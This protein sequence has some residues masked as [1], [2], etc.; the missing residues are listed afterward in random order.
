MQ[1]EEKAKLSYLLKHVE[2]REGKPLY[3]FVFCFAVCNNTKANLSS[4]F[5]ESREGLPFDVGCWIGCL[6]LVVAVVEVVV[7]GC[8]LLVAG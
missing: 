6:L 5:A 1:K 3:F 2:R 8:W 4:F 7:V